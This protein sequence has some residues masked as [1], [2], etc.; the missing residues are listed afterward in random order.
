MNKAFVS[1]AV[2]R[3]VIIGGGRSGTAI[4]RLLANDP[5][6]SPLVIDINYERIRLLRSEGIAAEEM[7]GDHKAQMLKVLSGASA[8]VCAAPHTVAPKVAQYARDAGCA[9]VDLCEDTDTRE[10]I[11]NI[12]EGAVTPFVSGCGL[13]PGLLS[14]MV[15]EMAGAGGPEDELYAYVGVLPL[16]KTNRLGYSN[17]WDISALMAEYTRPCAAISQGEVISL[18]SLEGYEKLTIGGTEYEAF[19]T[20][21]ALDDIVPNYVGRLKS[22]SFKTL[23][24]P[25]H[26]DYITFLLDDLGLS[27]KLYMVNQLLLNSLNRVE[28]DQVIVHLVRRTATGERTQTRLFQ[29]SSFEGCKPESTLARISASH[30][31]AVTDVLTR[32]L[33]CRGGLVCHRDLKFETLSQSAF[34]ATFLADT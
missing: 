33:E 23:R 7:S 4:A 13:A 1:N 31:C 8:V 6:F 16:H 19:N 24:Y 34:F 21:G 22:L 3:V 2:K 20:S 10:D 12:A 30:V 17:M 14:L 25:G 5:A 15:D 29:G 11:A 26:L 28:Q 18:P 32:G 27:K 9:Y